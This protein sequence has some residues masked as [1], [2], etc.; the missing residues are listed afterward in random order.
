MKLC[1]KFCA[2]RRS[3]LEASLGVRIPPKMSRLPGL[4][5]ETSLW[6][7]YHQMNVIDLQ[8]HVIVCIFIDSIS[9]A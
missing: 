5:T 4:E 2:Q 7:D 8:I 6:N 9:S 1:K 3:Y